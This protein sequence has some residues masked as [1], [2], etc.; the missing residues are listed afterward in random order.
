[1]HA[2]PEVRHDRSTGAAH[3]QA[4]GDIGTAALGCV[5]LS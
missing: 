1:V 2:K 3:R 4:V 5:R